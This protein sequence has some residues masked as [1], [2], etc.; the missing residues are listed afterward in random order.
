MKS[1]MKMF[2]CCAMFGLGLAWLTPTASA[3][4]VTPPD[5]VPLGCVDKCMGEQNA[6]VLKCGSNNSCITDCAA[7]GQIC[8][9]NC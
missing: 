9:G 8:I 1:A 6:C 7:K 2:A 3:S 4:P 5:A